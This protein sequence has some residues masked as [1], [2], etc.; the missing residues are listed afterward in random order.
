MTKPRTQINLPAFSK[1]D[2][3]IERLELNFLKMINQNGIGDLNLMLVLVFL[4][5]N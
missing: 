1:I 5:E 2:Q 3:T 4:Q